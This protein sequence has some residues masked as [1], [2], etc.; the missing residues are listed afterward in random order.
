MSPPLLP[1]Q[2]DEGENLLPT[3][4]PNNSYKDNA[5]FLLRFNAGD[6]FLLDSHQF[7]YIHTFLHV[8]SRRQHCKRCDRVKDACRLD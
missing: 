2:D 8:S 7:A 1:L 5:L 3:V 4:L 6:P